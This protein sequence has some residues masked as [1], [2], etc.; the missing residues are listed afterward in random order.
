MTFHLT[1]T[2]SLSRQ[3]S[4]SIDDSNDTLHNVQTIPELSEESPLL[5]SGSGDEGSGYTELPRPSIDPKHRT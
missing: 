4:F 1:S 5:A 3:E 2:P